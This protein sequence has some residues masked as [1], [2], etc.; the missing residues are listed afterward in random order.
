MRDLTKSLLSFSWAFSL[1]G[2]RQ[3]MR[4]A[5]PRTWLGGGGGGGGGAQPPP[6]PRE[7]Q[8][9]TDSLVD[10]LGDQLRRTFEAGDQVQRQ[11]VDTFFAFLGPFADLGG[12]AVPGSGAL[13]GGATAARGRARRPA[14]F[15]ASTS[16]G[17]Q[18]LISY[19][20]GRGRFSDDRRYI[21]LTNTI[22]EL[23]GR[24][25]GVHNGVWQ[26]LFSTP[27]ELFARPS[28]PTGPMNQ[29][30]GPVDRVA[31][32]ANTI[33][34]WTHAD[35]SRIDSVGPAASHLVPLAD[36]SLLFLVIT[37]QIV[38]QGTG[39]YRGARGLTQS[40]GATHVPRGTNLFT[41][42]DPTF[43]ALTFDTF[44]IRGVGEDRRARPPSVGGGGAS[45]GGGQAPGGGGTRT[46]GGT[47]P[48]GSAG[49]GTR[50]RGSAEGGGDG[51][52]IL[53]ECHPTGR[54]QDSRFVDV[55]GSKMHL[56]DVGV[57]EPVVMLHGNPTWSYL[58]RNVIPGVAG[59]ARVIVPDLI[60]MGASDKPDIR[61][62]FEEQ[63]RYLEALMDTLD[64]GPLT[65][66]LHDWGVI[67]GL[68][69]ARR[70]AERVRGIALMEALVRPYRSWDDFPAP[71]RDTFRSFRKPNEGYELVVAKNM[72]VEQ[73]LPGSMLRKLSAAE[74]DCYRAP[75]RD[76][77]HRRVIWRFANDLPI[78]GD[79]PG[80]ARA[81]DAYAEWIRQT[82]VPKLLMTAEPGAIT[83]QADAEWMRR[84]FQNLDV[85]PLGPG[86][87]YHQE[88]HPQEI[89]RAVAQWHAR[90][91]GS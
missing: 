82:P 14:I 71:L 38:T 18:V 8:S 44:K 63:A 17:E 30:V 65:L 86:I 46:G 32:T 37:A 3:A 28:E 12:A 31:V 19:T 20:R 11:I 75:F 4:A 51:E 85:V 42:P 1:F 52:A 90:V 40:L 34:R 64:T 76:P 47:R 54:R 23:D 27:E 15:D 69:W 77:L 36:G 84:H 35:G 61:Y 60:G 68:D 62:G 57:G 72:F 79:P 24:E 21:A 53:A 13:A 48:G 33:A 16:A 43:P 66:V 78:G 56:L 59:G 89:G 87:H 45:Y 2:T 88:D 80:A 22:Y 41:S 49:G 74:M 81:V 10:Q 50:P 26:A 29:P 91:T 73:L 25:N 55:L 70:H 39:R 5:D 6:M 67:L 7:I 58:W 9:V 83:T